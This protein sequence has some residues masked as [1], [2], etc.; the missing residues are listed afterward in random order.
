MESS[1]AKI[2]S[3][4]EPLPGGPGR[5]GG[6]PAIRASDRERDAATHRLQE[7]FAEGRLDDAE[8]DVRMRSA[9]SARTRADLDGLLADL[10]AARPG[11]S[12]PA[13]PQTS[14]GRK[15]GRLAV[16]FKGPVRRAGQWRVPERYTAVVYKG[17]G[18][19]DLR[20]AE[21]TA[22]VTTLV[23]VAYKSRVTILVP[24]GVRVE[25]GGFGADTDTD[26]AA[27]LPADAPVLHVRGFA[28]KGTVEVR[29]TPPED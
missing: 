28:Y 1:P 29:S 10:P 27:V 8:F 23:A 5:E 3:A 22:P 24:P 21:L 12:R 14:A 2:P 7:A 11:P 26:P 17:G 25:A 19:L 4:T 6:S 20:A 16:A 18:W 13:G 9:L 15:P